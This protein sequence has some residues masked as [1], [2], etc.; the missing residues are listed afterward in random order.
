[1]NSPILI[2]SS[3]GSGFQPILSGNWSPANC[4]A[5]VSDRQSASDP[6]PL[7]RTHAFEQSKI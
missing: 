4:F 3:K 2:P 5:I 7:S 6:F 1:M